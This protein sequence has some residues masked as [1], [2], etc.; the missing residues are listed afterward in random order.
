MAQRGF[1]GVSVAGMVTGDGLR[2]HALGKQDALLIAFDHLCSIYLDP[3][4]LN[5][6]T[7]KLEFTPQLIIN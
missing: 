6:E 7:S 5:L 2:N 4:Y 3:S 1:F